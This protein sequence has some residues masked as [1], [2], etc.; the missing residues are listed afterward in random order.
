M[1]ACE[2]ARLSR[3]ERFDLVIAAAARPRYALRMTRLATRFRFGSTAFIVISFACSETTEPLLLDP[4]TPAEP[5][6]DAGSTIPIEPKDAA[7]LDAAQTSETGPKRD[8]TGGSGGIAGPADLKSKGNLSF[9]INAPAGNPTQGLLVLLHGSGASNYASFV[10]MMQTVATRYGL[11]P[12]SVLAP[13]GQGWNEGNQAQAAQLLNRLIQEDLFPK[14]DI[15]KAK[16]VFSGQSSGG[17][18]LSS[19]FVP[20]YANAYRGGAF[21]QCGAAPPA[22]TFT[23]DA[24][25]RANFRLHFEITTGDSIWPVYYAQAVQRYTDA[26]M[27][28]TKDNAK[29]GGHCQFDQQQVIEDHIKFVL[30]LP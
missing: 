1:R 2:H 25:T 3:S 26:M 29:S 21:L 4:V 19:N 11:I 7:I 28:L 15:D 17:G 6:K 20:A 23:P 16:I 9:K 27:Q 10:L 14:Y 13:N 24:T 12:V 18:F 30:N 5:A 22:I 8:T